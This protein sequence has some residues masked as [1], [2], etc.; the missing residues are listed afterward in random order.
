MIL[1][2][3]VWKDVTIHCQMKKA[4]LQNSKGKYRV[5]IKYLYVFTYLK[6]VD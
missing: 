3:L 2:L 5:F 1:D 6:I 4:G